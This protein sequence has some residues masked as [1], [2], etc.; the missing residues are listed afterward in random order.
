MGQGSLEAMTS[1]SWSGWVDWIENWEKGERGGGRE[2][3]RG[4]GRRGEAGGEVIKGERGEEQD[5][6]RGA[7]VDGGVDEGDDKG[8]DVESDSIIL[9]V[10]YFSKVKVLFLRLFSHCSKI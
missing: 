2:R 7:V 9:T 10:R 1:R 6:E 5:R 8:V 4:R 3:E